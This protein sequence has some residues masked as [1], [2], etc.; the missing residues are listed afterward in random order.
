[1]LHI[2]GAGH[3]LDTGQS[4]PVLQPCDRITVGESDCRSVQHIPI[5]TVLSGHD[6]R[7]YIGKANILTRQITQMSEDVKHGLL[8]PRYRISDTEYFVPVAPDLYRDRCMSAHITGYTASDLILRYMQSRIY[9]CTGCTGHIYCRRK[10]FIRGTR[11]VNQDF[12]CTGYT[13]L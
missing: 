10:F 13:R 1:M 3:S 7:M 12:A 11:S 4:R 2:I 9:T 5:R 8:G 6:Q